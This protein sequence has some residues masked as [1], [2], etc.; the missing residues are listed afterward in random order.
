[1][2]FIYDLIFGPVEKVVD[3]VFCIFSA[4]ISPGG[5]TLIGVS[6]VINFLTLPLYNIAESIQDKERQ[7]QK[8]MEPRVKKIKAAFKGDEQFMIM[9]E[10]YRQ[11]NYHPLYSLRN[12]LSIVIQ[13]PFFVGAYNYLSHCEALQNTSF[14]FIQNLGEPD[15]LLSF[16]LG[17]NLVSVNILPIIMTSINIISGI[18]YTKGFPV[19]DKLQVFGLALIFLVLLYNSPSGLV[20][21]WI[22]NNIFSL[23]KNIIAKIKVK[24]HPTETE[25]DEKALEDK[26]IT[27]K[28]SQKG[29]LPLFIFSGLVLATT[30]GLVLP[31]SL[32]YTSPI[33]FSYL[34]ISGANNNPTS[35]IF[36]A[37]FLFLGLFLFWPGMFAKMFGNKFKVLSYVEFIMCICTITNVYIFSHDYGTFDNRF[38]LDNE[39]AIAKTSFVNCFFPLLIIGGIIAIVV[40]LEKKW[41][42]ARK[43]VLKYL[44]LVMMAVTLGEVALTGYKM[45]Y[46]RD[47]FER[48][49]LL[50]EKEN[51]KNSQEKD[52]TFFNLTKTGHNVI[53]LFVDR[54]IT[55]Y[56]DYALE[57]FPELKD[58]YKGFT[59]YQNCMSYGPFTYLATPAM[60]AGYDYTPEK[61]N[62]RSD[63]LLVD[64]HNESL[65]LMPKLFSDK[66]YDVVV[67]DTPWTN[68]SWVPDFTPFEQFPEIKTTQLQGKYVSEYKEKINSKAGNFQDTLDKQCKSQLPYFTMLQA[69]YPPLRELFYNIYK[70]NITGTAFTKNFSALYLLPDF[71]EFSNESNTYTFI[72]ND[73]PHEWF[74]LNA[75]YYTEESAEKIQ[76]INSSYE[77]VDNRELKAYQVNMATYKA[78]GNFL[79][80]LKE[81]DCYDNTR[82]IIVS[83]HG[84]DLSLQSF[85]ESVVENGS[86]LNCLLLYKDFN[87][88][89]ELTKSMDLM[90]NADTLY[91][92][93]EGLDLSENNPF[94]NEKLTKQRE[95]KNIIQIATEKNQTWN[96]SGHMGDT[97]FNLNGPTYV[98]KDNIFREENWTVLEAN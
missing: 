84:R 11:N 39:A 14:L 74:Y 4:L 5:I 67:S 19:K 94:T 34:G 97:Q 90:T 56:F 8:R 77:F 86:W 55:E 59:H 26:L 72:G 46:I 83:D 33:E 45:V 75:P 73:T 16:S 1:M 71:T 32:I 98:I 64:K 92:A 85:D 10:Y 93:T 80:Y 87:S 28:S 42:K 9:S 44:S 36:H 82:I 3:L 18:I 81:N 7:L 63:V 53:V 12:A 69:M 27:E 35:Y 6:L 25:K 70:S 47:E 91:L 66:D 79:D 78:I 2:N 51:L 23:M 96:A 68:Y 48:V 89:S 52:K 76:I 50:R 57:E 30:L 13:V 21:Y 20:F 61:L 17:S 38:I 29:Y 37:W 15:G 31:A 41:V 62:Q 24:K 58:S 65:M 54:A 40:L 49:T 88:T 22:L 95:D 60:L 43:R